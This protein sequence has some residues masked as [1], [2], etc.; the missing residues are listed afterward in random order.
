MA[1][2]RTTDRANH[3]NKAAQMRP[4][5]MPN[6]LADV[7][8]F[9]CRLGIGSVFVYSGWAKASDPIQFLKLLRQYDLVSHPLLQTAIAGLLPWLE[10]FCGA[11]LIL[12]LAVR[13]TA[14]LTTTLLVPFTIVVAAHAIHLQ[15]LSGLPICAI[16]FDCGCGT[17]EVN[18]CAKILENAGMIL[19]CALLALGG[20]GRLLALKYTLIQSK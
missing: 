9:I 16:R 20:L 3:S 11:L 10:L 18:V 14:L 6:K 5:P 4:G 13:G 17:G 12:G 2:S 1:S 7:I 15:R 8:G 19:G